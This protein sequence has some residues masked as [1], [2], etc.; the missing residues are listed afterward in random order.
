MAK[1]A[2]KPV[3]EFNTW[4]GTFGQTEAAQQEIILQKLAKDLAIEIKP[5]GWLRAR[6]ASRLLQCLQ[7]KQRSSTTVWQFHPREIAQF[8]W[9]V[10][11]LTDRVQKLVDDGCVEKT[12]QDVYQLS[13]WMDFRQQ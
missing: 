10:E 11:K 1:S 2:W 8:H 3:P 5:P 12:G 6:D 7:K 9:T 4:I 13:N